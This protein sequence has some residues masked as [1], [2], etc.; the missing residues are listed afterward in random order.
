ME[1][2]AAY[3]AKENRYSPEVWT[4]AY[5]RAIITK[6]YDSMQVF[7]ASGPEDV[8]TSIVFAYHAKSFSLL[9]KPLV[10]Y[11]VNTGWSTRKVFSIDTYR[12]WLKSYQTVIQNTKQFIS[13]NIPEFIPR[14][15]DMEVYFLK[16]FIFC[17]MA[18]Q[19]SFETRHAVFDLFPAF[20]SKDAYNTFY[21][22]LLWKYN[23]YE[24]YL[25]YAVPFKSKIKKL[26]KYIF[27]YFKF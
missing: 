10:N 18:S 27:R 22:E 6:A 7:Y 5:S 20:F 15:L 13:A 23:E 12:A 21:D 19:L 25:N 4:K 26:I 24:T 9:K 16:D 8:Y 17:R 3:L 1:R 11:S 2:I 14:C